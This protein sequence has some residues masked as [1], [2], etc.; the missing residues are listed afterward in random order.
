M[1][2]QL[3]LRRYGDLLLDLKSRWLTISLVDGALG[4]WPNTRCHRCWCTRCE[5]PKRAVQS[6]TGLALQNIK[7]AALIATTPQQLAIVFFFQ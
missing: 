3:Q 5:H 2:S 1:A 7:A 4:F 6:K